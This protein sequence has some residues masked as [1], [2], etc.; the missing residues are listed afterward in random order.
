MQTHAHP[1]SHNA[2]ADSLIESSERMETA[3]TLDSD[4]LLGTRSRLEGLGENRSACWVA[5]CQ[6]LN[7]RSDTRLHLT[8]I[9]KTEAN[10]S[11]REFAMLE[12]EMVH[13]PVRRPREIC[14]I[15]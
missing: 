3:L 2:H 4:N 15:S 12:A 7:P 13:S 8:R 14:I 10:D 1:N 11:I 9:E 5:Y 6:L